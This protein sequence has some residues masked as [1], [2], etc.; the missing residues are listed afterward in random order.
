LPVE[1]IKNFV[2]PKLFGLNNVI[3][4]ADSVNNHG[5]KMHDTIQS[6]PITETIDIS[7][8]KMLGQ[9]RTA[10][11]FIYQSDFVVK[12]FRPSFPK[13]AIDNEYL[14]CRAI[15]SLLDIPKAHS[16]LIMDGRD[17]IVFDFIRGRSG[18]KY[19]IGNPLKIK[20]FA[21]GF[22]GLHAGMHT[23][24]APEAVPDMKGILKRNMNM[25]EL[26]PPE[27]KKKIISYMENLPDGNSLC[28]GDY[29]PDNLILRDGKP[30]II[31]W[32]TATRGNPLADVARTSVLLK[33][34][35]PGPGTPF[36]ARTMLALVRKRLYKI[37]IDRYIKLTGASPW[38][39]ER[40][41]LPVMAA[42]LMEWI[43]PQEKNLLISI[44]N[45]KLDSVVQ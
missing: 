8:L 42:R 35:Q 15:G 41:E 13:Q 20:E 30:F 39:I 33:W 10:E 4:I 5:N 11:V 24:T 1:Y 3:N 44:I 26:L 28:H 9:G 38:D 31:D 45:K 21:V 7:Q 37:Y 34:A 14:V 25:H 29:H 23:I 16:H 36:I 27:S 40:W 12:L 43:P 22:A 32:M 17:A 19:I 18:F 6:Q 2:F